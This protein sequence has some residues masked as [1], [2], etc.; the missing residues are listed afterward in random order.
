MAVWVILAPIQIG[1]QIAYVSING[2]SMLPMMR[3]GDLALVREE[4]DYN[5]GD[6]V[7]YKNA[8][9]GMVIHR[10]VRLDGDKFV[11]K[12]DNNNFLDSYHPRESEVVGKLWLHLPTLGGTLSKLRTPVALATMAGGVVLM[13]FFP[14]NRNRRKSERQK[15]ASRPA[16]LN[17]CTEGGQSLLSLLVVVGLASLFLAY[18]SFGRDLTRSTTTNAAY[19]QSGSFT[20]TA[21]AGTGVYDGNRVTVGQPVFRRLANAVDY[22]FAYRFD[23]ELP[24]QVSGT[25]KVVAEV[26]DNRGWK[27]TLDLAPA[28][29]FEGGAFSTAATLDIREVQRAINNLEKK[30]GFERDLYTVAVAPQVSAEGTL[31]GRPVVTTFAPR[32]A[33]QLDDLTLQP[34][35]EG[36]AETDPY[37]PVQSGLLRLVG[38]EP[39]TV[40]LLWLDAPVSMVRWISLLGM[41]LALGGA[42]VLAALTLRMRSGDETARIEAQWGAMLVTVMGV[43]Q[44]TRKV[45][46]A[47]FEDLVRM[48]R[49]QGVGV[50]H[51][52]TDDGRRYYVQTDAAMYCYTVSE[53]APMDDER[54]VAATGTQQ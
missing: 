10:I 43:S 48:A 34:I 1:G 26:G 42:A 37:K 11:L 45:E 22:T 52:A 23:S 18:L 47:R 21:K 15:D 16:A 12:G 30:S 39:N 5:V 44:H 35:R 14:L 6:V 25:Y 13:A 51:D 2:A 50:L 17:L 4:R 54:T 33:F 7:T 41:L 20:Y 29:R 24:S 19:A 31:A 49:A 9:L 32:L 53:A 38:T 28:A 46:V 27:R 40:S 8:D 3:T 36:L